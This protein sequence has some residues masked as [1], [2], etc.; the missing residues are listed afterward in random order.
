MI[1][2]L[3]SFG[4]APCAV[5]AVLV[6]A[7]ADEP[8]RNDPLG[9]QPLPEDFC[10]PEGISAE[11]LPAL[12]GYVEMYENY[13]WCDTGYT[14][15]WRLVNCGT[16]EQLTIEFRDDPFDPNHA[17]VEQRFSEMEEMRKALL[18][19]DGEVSL[20]EVVEHFVSLGAQAEFGE[21]TDFERM[22]DAAGTGM[23]GGILN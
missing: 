16:G 22:C 19:S 21:L 11:L 9:E 3:K 5:A 23:L 2:M 13:F 12:P 14:T 4:I 6:P 1:R 17:V 18:A 8:A 20:R 15:S 7:F 10:L